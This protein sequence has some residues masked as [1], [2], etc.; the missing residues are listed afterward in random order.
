MLQLS[1]KYL[2]EWLLNVFLYLLSNSPKTHGPI[3]I[4]FRE[5]VYFGN[6][7]KQNTKLLFSQNRR[8]T[9]Y[10][11]I[12]AHNVLLTFPSHL[13]VCLCFSCSKN[14][15][16]S[17]FMYYHNPQYISNFTQVHQ[18]GPPK[19]LGPHLSKNAGRVYTF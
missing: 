10:L 16:L 9:M 17:I 2:L 12:S 18:L 19:R 7:V 13:Q 3:L 11:F 15:F 8:L 5:C 6:F 14:L 4:K 1:K